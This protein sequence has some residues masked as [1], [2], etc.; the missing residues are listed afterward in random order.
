[1]KHRISPG[2]IHKYLRCRMCMNVSFSGPPSEKKTEKHILA[3]VELKSADKNPQTESQMGLVAASELS[4]SQHMPVLR[5]LSAW[6][7]WNEAAHMFT[8][9]Q[10]PHCCQGNQ[11]WIWHQSQSAMAVI[12][13]WETFGKPKGARENLTQSSTSHA[14]TTNEFGFGVIP[15]KSNKNIKKTVA[16]EYAPR[17]LGTFSG[18]TYCYNSLKTPFHP[19]QPSS[20]PKHPNLKD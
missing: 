4:I 1:M 9:I 14:Q 18:Y 3:P 11:P 20:I 13:L 12:S 15:K 2:T 8:N 10:M 6:K 19:R 7:P 16:P 5:V 17:I